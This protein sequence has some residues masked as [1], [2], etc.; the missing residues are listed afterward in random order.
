M[1]NTIYNWVENRMKVLFST[2]FAMEV[3]VVVVGVEPESGVGKAC[4]L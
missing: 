4:P 3:L 2:L 1:N